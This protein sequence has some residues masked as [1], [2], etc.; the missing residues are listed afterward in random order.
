MHAVPAPVQA[1]VQ[2]ELDDWRGEHRRGPLGYHVFDG[3]P[4]G[5]IRAVCMAYNARARLTDAE[6]IKAVAT[7][8]ALPPARRMPCSPIAGAARP[9]PCARSVMRRTVALT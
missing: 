1:D 8:A 2:T 3:I 7:R 6:A 4:E 9:A 5:T